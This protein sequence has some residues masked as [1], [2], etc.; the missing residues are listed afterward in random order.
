MK[1]PKSVLIKDTVTL[2]LTKYKYKI[3]IVSPL[4]SLFRKKDLESVATTLNF[5][6]IKDFNKSFLRIKSDDDIKYAAKICNI[7]RKSEDFSCRV[8]SPFLN[9]YTNDSS[10]IEELSNVDSTK[11]KF[12]HL[13]NKNNPEL[14]Q[15]SIIVK[16]IDFGYKVSMGTCRKNY[17]NFI[18]WSQ[19]SNKI[20]LTQRCIRDLSKDRSW[21]GSYF[22]VKD[23]K[24]LT[25]V[26]VFLGSDIS[27]IDNVIKA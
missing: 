5:S 13:P 20:K 15:G 3:V 26:K 18:A 17:S 19:Q 1:L 10:L 22:Y 6:T 27:K 7:L 4:A 21:G 24:T 16:K 2:F 11:I 25:M 14:F 12:I 9:V 23:D 8:E